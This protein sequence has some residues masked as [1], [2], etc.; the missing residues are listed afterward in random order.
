V[1]LRTRLIAKFRALEAQTAVGQELKRQDPLA[2]RHEFS[3]IPATVI[4]A[5]FEEWGDL[6][7]SDDVEFLQEDDV[8]SLCLGDSENILNFDSVRTYLPEYAA[9]GVDIAVIDS[10]VDSDHPALV[11]RVVANQNFTDDPDALDYNGHGTHVAGIAAGAA[12]GSPFKGVAPGA[13]IYS[14]KAFRND[15]SG[16]SSHSVAAIEWAVAHGVKVISFSGGFFAPDTSL[17][18]HVLTVAAEAAVAAGVVFVAAAGN[19]G[20]TAGTIYA[21]AVSPHVIAVGNTQKDNTIR[22]SSSRGPTTEGLAKPD[23]VATGTGIISALSSYSAL[24]PVVGYPHYTAMT[25][26]SMA[27]PQ[28]AGLAALIQYASWA[29]NQTYLTPAQV[30]AAIV[31]TCTDSSLDENTQGA[32]LVHGYYAILEALTNKTVLFSSVNSGP[33]NTTPINY[34]NLEANERLIHEVLLVALPTMEVVGVPVLDRLQALDARKTF[35]A[36]PVS[37][38]DVVRAVTAQLSAFVSVVSDAIESQDVAQV[39]LALNAI[40]RVTAQD[41]RAVQVSAERMDSLLTQDTTAPALSSLLIDTL[42]AE[43][44][45]D[46]VAVFKVL[47]VLRTQTH[48]GLAATGSLLLALLARGTTRDAEVESVTEELLANPELQGLLTRLVSL[49]DELTATTTAEYTLTILVSETLRG[50]ALDSVGVLGHYFTQNSDLLG[51]WVG[52]RLGE[53]PATGW[54]MNT[55]GDMPVSRYENYDFNS[56]CRLGDVYLGAKDEGLY[57]LD[58]ETD[59]GVLIESAVR[60]MMLDFGSPAMKRVQSAYI[61]YTSNGRLLLKVRV[62][63]E[64]Q[65]NEQWYEAQELPAQAPREQMVRVGRGLRSRYWQFDLV[66]IDGA[67]FELTDL[68]LY[69]VYLNRRV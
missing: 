42:F 68:E 58:G 17:L 51:A 64:G 35:W 12:A 60:T 48:Y 5:T 29:K 7:L 28:V 56:F 41:S 53:E 37:L 63:T 45:L 62:T 24:T 23:V 43:G 14:A 1:T 52:F 27:A 32:G 38:T 11:G 47:D 54:V 69:P 9:G 34:N 10:G 16:L 3:L 33:S 31:A 61:G 22:N 59:D 20:P 49:Y 6:I 25:G 65:L 4:E 21:P 2:V 40:E 67:D 26:T 39:L 55:E 8:G 18:T 15:G 46:A 50:A 57:L 66:N 44:A 13:R 19:D 30:K 36:R